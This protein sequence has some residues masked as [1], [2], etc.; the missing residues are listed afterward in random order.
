[1]KNLKTL[2]YKVK[3]IIPESNSLSVVNDKLYYFDENNNEFKIGSDGETVTWDDVQDKPATFTPSTH[4]HPIS[5][6]TGLGTAATTS[7]SDYA[8]A[9]QGALADTALQISDAVDVAEAGKVVKYSNTGAVNTVEPQLPDNAVNLAYLNLSLANKVDVVSGMGLSSE[10]FTTDE[11]AKLAGL[12]DV[13]YK[14]WFPSLLALQTKY[15]TADEG[16]HAFVDDVSGS[17]LYIW[18]VD[19]TEWVARVGESTE[20]TPA[21]AKVL[22]ESNPDTNVFTDVL[23]AKLEA[24]T[25]NFTSSLKTAYDNAVS[26]ISV[27]GANLLNHLSNKNNPHDVTASQIGLGNVDNTK[28]VDK[29]ISTP[30]KNYVDTQLSNV[31]LSKVWT[32]DYSNMESTNRI[33]THGGTWTV[34]ADRKG[35]VKLYTR[36]YTGGVLDAEVFLINGKVMDNIW[37]EATSGSGTA[38]SGSR[39]G[40]FQ[41]KGGDTIQVY[42][43]LER[44]CFFIPGIWV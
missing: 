21:Q 25:S 10:N 18:D 9:A 28:D 3:P 36:T 29:P 11:K 39:S 17:V 42:G 30:T 6:I 27:N 15:P 23:K 16:A 40:L 5:Q 8:T 12:E 26:W 20:M 1:M 35:W 24:F 4:T 2:A 32:P 14:G 34:P 41:V 43:N 22:Y 44:S 38:R 7:I 31:Q 33:T 19:T 13:H 37:Q